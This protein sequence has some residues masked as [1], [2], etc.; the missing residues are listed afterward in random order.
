MSIFSLALR[1]LILKVVHTSHG[2]HFGN[3]R[4]STYSMLLTSLQTPNHDMD[5]NNNDDKITSKTRMTMIMISITIIVIII[6]MVR[7]I[8]PHIDPVLE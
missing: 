6:V 4:I 3:H 2:F 5:D 8:T 1:S 7:T